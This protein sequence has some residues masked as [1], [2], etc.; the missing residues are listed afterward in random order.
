M[1]A[2]EGADP[3]HFAQSYNIVY[4]LMLM[5]N[6]RT[7]TVDIGEGLDVTAYTKLADQRRS[8]YELICFSWTDK[9]LGVHCYR[10]ETA[11]DLSFEGRINKPSRS[12]PWIDR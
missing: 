4:L 3:Q 10:G 8:S 1:G 9:V 2:P 12:G 5:N 7:K 11:W 6:V